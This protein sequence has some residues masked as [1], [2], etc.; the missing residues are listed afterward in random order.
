MEQPL[1]LGWCG[2]EARFAAPVGHGAS[3]VGSVK[4]DHCP[5]SDCGRVPRGLQD[6]AR[7]LPGR[8]L[9]QV[10]RVSS[11]IRLESGDL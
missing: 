1:S 6:K 8:S 7:P 3:R 5:E 9:A 11:L 2:F 4:W 10:L